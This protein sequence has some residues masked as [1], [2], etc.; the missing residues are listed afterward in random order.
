MKSSSK[1]YYKYVLIVTEGNQ[2]D[3]FIYP[4]HSGWGPA[5]LTTSDI[6][7]ALSFSDFYEAKTFSNKKGLGWKLAVKK[8]LVKSTIEFIELYK[9]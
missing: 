8:I 6:F 1:S 9:T 7:E 4:T 2:K 5:Y 3:E